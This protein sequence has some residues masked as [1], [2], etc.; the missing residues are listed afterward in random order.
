MK[1]KLALSLST[2]I[3]IICFSSCNDKKIQQKEDAISKS[4]NHIQSRLEN[5][6]RLGPTDELD[7]DIYYTN[8][9]FNCELN[10]Y[11]FVHLDISTGFGI[12]AKTKLNSEGKIM[13]A[14]A[15]LKEPGQCTRYK[16]TNAFYEE[17]KKVDKYKHNITFEMELSNDDNNDTFIDIKNMEGVK[18]IKN[19]IL[20]IHIKSN[21]ENIASAKYKGHDLINYGQQFCRSIITNP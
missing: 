11:Q 17:G 4:V 13:S 6:C 19:E 10:K 8:L 14:T 21:D 9:P 5:N 3:T 7:S 1:T 20:D 16:I 15:V 12:F 2:L 18:M